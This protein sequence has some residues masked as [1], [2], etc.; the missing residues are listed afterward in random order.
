MAA[1]VLNSDHSVTA[2]RSDCVTNG[3][4]HQAEFDTIIGKLRFDPLGE[5][6]KPRIPFDQ[7]Q[8]VIGN[9]I[10]QFEQAGKQ[11]IRD[12]PELK[13][14]NLIYP[15]AKARKITACTT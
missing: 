14:G 9:D 1:L 4:A 12:P 3:K 15:F 5:W 7:Y 2:S 6:V 10:N 8:N 11:V 13:S